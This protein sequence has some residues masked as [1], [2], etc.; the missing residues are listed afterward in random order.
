MTLSSPEISRYINEQFVPCWQSV[1]PVPQ[2]TIDFGNGKTLHRTLAGNTIFSVCLPNGRT[3]DAMPGIYTPE[4]LLQELRATRE[5]V[6]SAAPD[7]KDHA[8]LDAEVRAWHT[9]QV[10]LALR[11]EALRMTV[12]KA[13]VESPLLQALGINPRQALGAGN[14]LTPAPIG[15][16][17]N[18]DP[19]LVPTTLSKAVVQAPL[20]G[21][22][23]GPPAPSPPVSAAPATPVDLI[24]DPKAAF[25]KVAARIDDLSKHPATVRQ[26]RAR[27]D[28]AEQPATP[29]EIGKQAVAADSRINVS[30]AR[31]A[32]HLLF[33]G[34]DRL[35]TDLACRDT[36]YRDLLHTPVDDPYLGLA[37][38]LVP[39]TPNGSSQHR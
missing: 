4:A 28:G 24:S 8:G 19:A 27:A 3:M 6:Q 1:R 17:A 16:P 15:P 7:M 33:A 34:Y 39:G 13:V 5:F 26:V 2:V 20:L 37:D 35:P 36:I 30:L 21:A 38:A 10:T 14:G 11:K 31:P 25:A 29:E 12:S 18:A 9:G 32:V 22:V 23:D